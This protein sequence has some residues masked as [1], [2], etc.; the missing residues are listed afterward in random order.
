[1]NYKQRLEACRKRDEKIR[2]LRR[3]GWKVKRL[4]R[5]YG[6][7]KQRVSQIVNGKAAR[8]SK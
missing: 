4:A 1:M 8:A 5:R 3:T 2:L 6:I 7:T